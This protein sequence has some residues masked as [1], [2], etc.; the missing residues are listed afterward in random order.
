MATITFSEGLPLLAP[1]PMARAEDETSDGQLLDRFIYTHDDLAFAEL[2]RR[3]GSMVLGV[4]RRVLDNRHDAEDCFQAVFL[5][6]V[7]KAETIQPR[8]MV[9]NWLYG[10]AYRT[11]L[12]SKK[13][14][15]R[16]R[17][18][19]RKRC[20]MP[21]PEPESDW[22]DLKPLLDQE[23]SRLPDK[24]RFVLVACDLE[25]QTRKEVARALH[26][27]EGTVA[28]RLARA[29]V[30]LAKRLA[31]KNLIISAGAL[32]NLLSDRTPEEVP[33]ALTA[34]TAQAAVRVAAG[35]P[36][37]GSVGAL[38]DAVAASLS[39]TRTQIAAGALM[40]L[41][42][43]GLVVGS[44]LPSVLADRS[45]RT[46]NVPFVPDKPEARK[47]KPEEVKECLVEH[48]DLARRTIQATRISDA[49]HGSEILDVRVG[50]D[51]RIMVGDKEGTLADL[52]AGMT[53]RLELERNQ[54]GE[55][56]AVLVE[57]VGRPIVGVVQAIDEDSVTL[58]TDVKNGE[59]VAETFVLARG[60]WVYINGKKAKYGELKKKMKVVLQVP[61]GKKKVVG[62]SAGPKVVGRVKAVVVDKRT[63]SLDGIADGF[64]VATDAH[65]L[66]DGKTRTLADLRVGM[67]VSV[68]M[69]ADSEHSRALAIAA[70]NALRAKD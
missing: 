15:A 5:V 16:R 18:R 45:R 13:L 27:P 57:I 47:D 8:Q 14:T 48:V 38:T 52:H 43:L 64:C 61:P 50:P 42:L 36:I 12:E 28:S 51:A 24:Y 67:I 69:S 58:H 44:F 56:H 1:A 53:L 9:G 41:A 2:V 25:G 32:A 33:L 6:L 55:R 26:V 21:R 62:V 70:R 68:Q 46:E 40:A 35:K 66:V 30:M 34:S 29:R 37:A 22:Q 10:V 31:R 65:V 7:R 63:L 39:W 4:C 17:N 11:A 19:E 49:G 23:L 3:H 54:A 59:P 60:A 20:E